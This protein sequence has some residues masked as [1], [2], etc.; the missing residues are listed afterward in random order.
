MEF[1]YNPPQNQNPAGLP[2]YGS[3]PGWLTTI[4]GDRNA[5]NDRE[6]FNLNA[7]MKYQEQALQ[8]EIMNYQNK[9]NSPLEQMKRYQEAGL[10]PWLAYGNQQTP[11]AGT[12]S[13]ASARGQGRGANSAQLAQ[14]SNGMIAQMVGIAR[15][16]R[17]MYDYFKYGSQ[18]S[19]WSALE[20]GSRA[21]MANLESMFKDWYMRSSGIEPAHQKRIEQGL[22]PLDTS[23]PE[24][25]ANSM[26]GSQESARLATQEEKYEQLKGLVG[27]IPD[28]KA[29]IKALKELD[30]YRLGIM[31][32]QNDA[33]LSLDTGFPGLDS[34]LRMV[35]YWLLNQKF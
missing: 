35:G 12:S 21:S 27:L 24:I 33:I 2:D 29:R 16:G 11:A 14:A 5:L 22:D 7:Q 10:S 28:Q 9:Y 4:I 32:G 15:A 8:A 3:S 19:A 26:R 13:V 23:L 18:K 6:A 30:D 20:A 34:F 31:K 1:V 17:E 25:F